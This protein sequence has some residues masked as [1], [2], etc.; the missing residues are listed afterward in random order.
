MSNGHEWRQLREI[1][2][3]E[4]MSSSS[5][6]A[7]YGLRLQEVREM[8][9]EV[10]KQV[11]LPINIGEHIFLTI[12]NVV[13]NMLWGDS[14]HGE[15]RK[16]V[17]VEFRQVVG[18]IVEMF[19]KPNISDLF[20]VLARFD[21]QGIKS[22]TKKLVSWFDRIFDTVI[23][24]RMDVDVANKSE[25]KESNKDFLQFLLELQNQ[26][27]SK[28]SLSTSQ[29]KGLLL[30]IVLGGSD[31][32]STTLEW[33]MAEI[34]KNPEIIRKVQEEL[35]EVVG[36]DSI[37]EESHIPKLHYLNS[38]L[39]ETLRL[40][41]ALP[42]LVPHCPSQ[43]CMVAG[44]TIPEGSRIFVNVWAVQRDP[45]AWENLL[46]FQPERFLKDPG[47]CDYQGNNFHYLPFGSGR[48][49]CAGISRAEKLVAYVLATLLHSFDWKLP[50]GV[51]LDLSDK[52]G[53]ILKKSE[54]LD[55][56][57]QSFT[58][59]LLVPLNLCMRERDSDT[60]IMR[61][62]DSGTLSL[63]GECLSFLC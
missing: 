28:T 20:P 33:A 16:N 44:Y 63:L 59:D 32:T 23:F 26:G 45:E 4:L 11:G 2:V 57:L 41:P 13:M 37:V 36:N 12:L 47:K 52:F 25:N 60:F 48:R 39:K 21:L 61:D 35:D 46:E 58:I 1:F 18:E 40:H 30:D 55:Y 5:L 8:V 9:R 31:T 24:H 54:L 14:L 19:G 51:K 3:R 42:L 7:G 29:I 38:V 53:I 43:S 6:N 17:G 22:N 62:C 49:V 34:L 15:D 56:P 27:D 10:Y 50:E